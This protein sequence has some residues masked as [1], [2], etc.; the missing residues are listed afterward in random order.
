MSPDNQMTPVE[1]DNV[2]YGN[3]S[4]WVLG[5]SAVRVVLEQFGFLSPEDLTKCKLTVEQ[6]LRDSRKQALGH[7]DGVFG[8]TVDEV[9][10]TMVEATAD[11]LVNEVE[12][13]KGHVHWVV[14]V[15]KD[16]L[17][18]AHG[19]MKKLTRRER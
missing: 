7:S 16:T 18:D 2:M 19:Q 9:I 10:E 3:S 4:T 6:R 14:G 11:P 17:L 8:L 5:P 12:E 15:L 13:R 1:K